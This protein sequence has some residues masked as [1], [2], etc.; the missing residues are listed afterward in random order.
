MT[1]P[2]GSD[3]FLM[4]N[5]SVVIRLDDQPTIFAS[6]TLNSVIRL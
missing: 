5:Q 3:I 2:C 4:G 6:I 1:P